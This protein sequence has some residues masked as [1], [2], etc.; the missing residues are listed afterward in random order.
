MAFRLRLLVSDR[1]FA[2]SC[3]GVALRGPR[4]SS[5]WSCAKSS[6][7][8]TDRCP[9]RD[10]DPRSDECSPSSSACGQRAIVCHP[11]SRPTPSV[12]GIVTSLEPSGATV[13]ESFREDGSR[14]TC[15][16][17]S[18]VLATENSTWA[19]CRLRGELKKLGAEISTT[20]IRRIV[21]EK[22]RPPQSARPG[23]SS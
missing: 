10:S 19:Y 7:Y 4:T 22:R 9:G 12:A 20:T 11:S 14:I 5:C 17:S 3:S 8:C 6:R 18:G 15:G 2:C 21:A 23:V 13:T 1:S 16:F